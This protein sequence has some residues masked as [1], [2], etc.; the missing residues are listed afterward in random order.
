M[1]CLNYRATLSGSHTRH[2][3]CC[4]WVIL[5]NSSCF[6]LIFGKWSTKCLRWMK[7]V[8]Y[9]G[10]VD[11]AIDAVKKPR[12]LPVV[13]RLADQLIQHTRQ[14]GFRGRGAPVVGGVDFAAV[15]LRWSGV[16]FPIWKWTIFDAAK[17]MS[18][19]ISYL[20]MDHFRRRNAQNHNSIVTFFSPCLLYSV[21]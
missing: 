2:I 3:R 17:R 14:T 21:V 7:R 16:P 10:Q 9:L 18:E 13:K 12:F 5:V 20:K 6:S 4:F 11:L 15:V 1:F 19:A 8:S